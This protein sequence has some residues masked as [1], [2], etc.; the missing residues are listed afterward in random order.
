MNGL[1]DEDVLVSRDRLPVGRQYSVEQLPTRYLLQKLHRAANEESILTVALRRPVI[2]VASTTNESSPA[3]IAEVRK[4]QST[5]KSPKSPHPNRKKSP[6][7][8]RKKS[9]APNRKKSPATPK[10]GHRPPKR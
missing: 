8:Q 6:A 10:K 4:K 5:S 7:A 2:P 3:L 1:S 9:P